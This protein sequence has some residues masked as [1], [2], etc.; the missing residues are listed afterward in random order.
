MEGEE[1]I[2]KD[3]LEC[4]WKRQQQHKPPGSQG[5]LLLERVPCLTNQ[6]HKIKPMKL[7]EEIDD[8]YTDTPGA[9][10]RVMPF[11][12]RAHP[13][14]CSLQ[15]EISLLKHCSPPGMRAQ[16]K[17]SP[18]GLILQNAEH[19]QLSYIPLEGERW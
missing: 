6:S 5:G 7:T 8:Q 11:G 13:A 1:L 16:V 18:P 4:C 2:I 15:K 17:N 10:E 9:V 12:Y 3:L 19:L 14:R